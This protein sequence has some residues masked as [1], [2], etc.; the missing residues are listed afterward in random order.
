MR[1]KKLLK[2]GYCTR[3][4]SVLLACAFLCISCTLEVGDIVRDYGTRCQVAALDADGKPSLFLATEVTTNITA[5]S[6]YR[7]AATVGDGTWQVPSSQQIQQ[8]TQCRSALNAVRNREH[9]PL[10]MEPTRFYWTS[11]PAGPQHIFA[12]GPLGVRPYFTQDAAYIGLA[13][14]VVREQ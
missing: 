12:W 11:T 2:P 10:V 6:A 1:M 9:L 13:V 4:F 8:L 3:I 5:D 7:W 14:K